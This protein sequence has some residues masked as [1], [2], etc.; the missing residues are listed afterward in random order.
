MKILRYTDAVQRQV[1]CKTKPEPW[2]HIG[3]SGN[4]FAI[5]VWDT[6]QVVEDGLTGMTMLDNVTGQPATD[7][8]VALKCKNDSAASYFNHAWLDA[9]IRYAAKQLH[10]KPD[11][12]DERS[13][14]RACKSNG[15]FAQAVDSLLHFKEFGR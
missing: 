2:L 8:H 4:S 12:L 1:G 10:C 5:W 11:E 15:K 13:I 7:N 9:C 6:R 14:V 3:L